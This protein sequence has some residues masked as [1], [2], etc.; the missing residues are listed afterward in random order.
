MYIVLYVKYVLFLS[1]LDE[2][3][4]PAQVLEKYPEFKFN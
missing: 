4:I 2:N 3:W 1:D